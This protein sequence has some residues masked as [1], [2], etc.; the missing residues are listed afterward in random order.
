MHRAMLPGECEFGPSKLRVA[1]LS[2]HD[3]EGTKHPDDREDRAT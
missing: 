3:N 1:K 2:S